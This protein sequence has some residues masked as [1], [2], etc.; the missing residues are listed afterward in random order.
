MRFAEDDGTSLPS[1]GGDVD[2]DRWV[3]TMNA[4]C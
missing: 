1:R 2:G 4:C 3:K